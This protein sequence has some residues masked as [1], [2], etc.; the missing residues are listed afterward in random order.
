MLLLTLNPDQELLD[1]TVLCRKSA[2]GR[3]EQKLDVRQFSL[4]G[5]ASKKLCVHHLQDLS[6]PSGRTNEH[7]Y[8][9]IWAF[10]EIENVNIGNVN[11]GNVNI[12]CEG[13]T[14]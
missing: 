6:G 9:P 5:S 12:E 11:I 10:L 3:W 13:Q 2:V 14:L 8:V 7:C 4:S 1:L